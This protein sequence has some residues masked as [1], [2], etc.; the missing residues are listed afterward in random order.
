MSRDG[1]ADGPQQGVMLMKMPVARRGKEIPP[2]MLM[3]VRCDGSALVVR[4]ARLAGTIQPNHEGTRMQQEA[5]SQ[6]NPYTDS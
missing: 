6:Q 3:T 5:A 1:F 2:R 4:T